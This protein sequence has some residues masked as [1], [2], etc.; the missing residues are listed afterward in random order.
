V[1]GWKKVESEKIL[2]SEVGMRKLEKIEDGKMSRWKK[3]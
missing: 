2:N 3:E 1:G